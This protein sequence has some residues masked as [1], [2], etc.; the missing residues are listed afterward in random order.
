MTLLRTVENRKN[1]GET[2]T[3][4]MTSGLIV[5]GK[6]TNSD[7][8]IVVVET[9]TGITTLSLRH[10]EIVSDNVPETISDSHVKSKKSLT[11]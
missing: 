3:F 8:E 4:V 1:K 7:L 2:T 9:K 5:T 11:K 10:I 6:I